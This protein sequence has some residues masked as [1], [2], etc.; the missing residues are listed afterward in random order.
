MLS[1]LVGE[2][3]GSA[4][5]AEVMTPGSNHRSQEVPSPLFSQEALDHVL[6]VLQH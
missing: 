1:S 5:P 3:V 2:K 6:H 4:F